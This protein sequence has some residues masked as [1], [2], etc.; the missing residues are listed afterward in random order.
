MTQSPTDPA[1]VWRL[2]ERADELV[3]YASNRDPAAARAQARDVLAQA[4][5]ALAGLA[6]PKAAAALGQQIRKRFEDLSRTG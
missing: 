5:V 6:D 4:E 1:G 3:K 2:I